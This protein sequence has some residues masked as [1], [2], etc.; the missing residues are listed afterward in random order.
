MFRLDLHDE[1]DVDYIASFPV[2]HSGVVVPYPQ[3]G[4]E[5][6]ESSLRRLQWLEIDSIFKN[7]RVSVGY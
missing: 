2:V 4:G 7:M 1:I 5:E 6:G 3:I